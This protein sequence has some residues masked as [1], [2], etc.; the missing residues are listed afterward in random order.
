MDKVIMIVGPTAVGKSALGIDL[1]KQF[2]GEIISGDSMQIFRHLDIGTA[3]VLP[4]E[5]QGVPHHLLN[6]RNPDEKF[7]AHDFQ[8]AAGNLVRKITARG[9]VPII[10]GGTG[11]YLRMFLLGWQL[12]TERQS[13]HITDGLNNE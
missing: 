12:G 2:N 11:F 3:K 6:I 4:G 9:H 7:S 5:M 10:V 1:A 8:Q 13:N